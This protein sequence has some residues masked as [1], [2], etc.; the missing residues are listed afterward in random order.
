[1]AG[2]LAVAAEV[3]DAG[4]DGF[5]EVAQPDVIHGHAGRQRVAALG[6]PAGQCQTAAA[7]DH[8]VGSKR[9]FCVG[10]GRR[11]LGLLL[12]FGQQLGSA[13]QLALGLGQIRQGFPGGGLKTLVFF[14]G[15]R[16]A[17]CSG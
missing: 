7:A 9:T 11:L 8:R 12:C 17:R 13:G 15:V 4:H 2:R 3:K 1:M 14:A 16:R 5:A 6:D 10:G